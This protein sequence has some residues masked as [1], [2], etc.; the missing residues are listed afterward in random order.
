MNKPNSGYDYT[1][2]GELLAEARDETKRLVLINLL[3]EERARDRLAEQQAFDREALTA[4]TVAAV[5]GSRS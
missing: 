3:I 4:S 2:Y 1:R 5:L